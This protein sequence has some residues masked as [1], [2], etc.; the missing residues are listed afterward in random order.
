M[1]PA[2]REIYADA[3]VQPTIDQMESRWAGIEEACG[4][5]S[6][7]KF[8]QLVGLFFGFRPSN[9]EL[10]DQFRSCFT[11]NDAGFPTSND[12]EM[13][14][15]AG[16]V[17]EAII[18]GMGEVNVTSIAL[19]TLCGELKGLTPTPPSLLVIK[20]ASR[21]L[22]EQSR[23][24][25][26]ASTIQTPKRVNPKLHLD[27]LDQL[28]NEN[29]PEAILKTK[30]AIE[31]VT[32]SL[33]SVAASNRE[34]YDVARTQSEELN[35]LWWLFGGRS[36]EFDTPFTELPSECTPLIAAKELSELTLVLPGP[37]SAIAIIERS[38]GGSREDKL[39]LIDAINALDR[40]WRTNWVSSIESNEMLDY[41]PVHF[42]ICE[43]LRTETKKSWFDPAKHKF[44]ITSDRLSRTDLAQQVYQESLLLRFNGD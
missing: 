8:F 33:R 30:T 32:N 18:A 22:D 37:L 19:A 38:I 43:S 13:Q 20:A 39:S 17:L 28:V 23:A 11:K 36:R 34:L 24:A 44:Q 27:G 15:L 3:S 31:R 4:Q 21:K 41:C 10:E 5:F 16:A 26:S 25:R 42:S 40:D 1:R 12:R 29:Y 35:M 7:E 2:F 14:V 6:D 9:G